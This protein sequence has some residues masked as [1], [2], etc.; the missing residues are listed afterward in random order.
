[1]P[2]KDYYVILGISPQES[3]SGV[4]S[5]WRDL[6]RRYHPDRAGHESTRQFQEVSEAYNVLGDPQ[7]RAAY[8]RGRRRAFEQP[9]GRGSGAG[10]GFGVEPL[11]P[12]PAYA[13]R[14]RTEPGIGG[15]LSI[16]DDFIAPS[17]AFDE[18][19]ERFR[20]NLN[21]EWPAK[22][23]R[24]DALNLGLHLSAEE[25]WRG[26]TVELGV[27][28]F[29]P[30]PDC[31]G[32]GRVGFFY[33]CAGCHETGAVM[34]EEPVRLRIPAGVTDGT[35]FEIPLTGLGIRNFYLRVLIRVAD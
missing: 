4:R 29:F 5:A 13:P 27:P 26:G 7:R 30:C 3:Q 32:T 17:S 22:S 20:R 19:F 9:V 34:R 12:G 25:A 6:A 2:S 18:V 16:L 28:I 33:A 23:G 21:D 11:D 14:T 31:H 8:D 10:A 35:L 1:M 24:L 15:R